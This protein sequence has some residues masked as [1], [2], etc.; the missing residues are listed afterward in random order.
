VNR[1]EK[2]GVQG[3]WVIRHI[4]GKSFARTN[5]N[6]F[7]I[8]ACRALGGQRSRSA[9]QIESKASDNDFIV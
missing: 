5:T 9:A 2:R 7:S 6:Y 4:S 8:P 1:G 3:W